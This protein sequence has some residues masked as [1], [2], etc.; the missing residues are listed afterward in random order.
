MAAQLIINSVTD[1]QRAIFRQSVYLTKH[2]TAINTPMPG[3]KAEPLVGERD[4]QIATRR[5]APR[6]ITIV[7]LQSEPFEDIDVHDMFGFQGSYFNAQAIAWVIFPDG[8]DFYITGNFNSV[9]LFHG[10]FNN[11]LF[12]QV[13]E[14]VYCIFMH[15]GL[16]I[17]QT[18]TLSQQL[19]IYKNAEISITE[20]GQILLHVGY[21]LRSEIDYNDPEFNNGL[22]TTWETFE[23]DVP[24][25]A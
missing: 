4:W 7:W 6:Q 24:R 17:T 22:S 8:R 1:E 12:V 3:A 2:L 11:L 19:G 23:V 15:E 16:C 9:P 20:S 10:I 21:L 5:S 14:E 18:F 25:V 13:D